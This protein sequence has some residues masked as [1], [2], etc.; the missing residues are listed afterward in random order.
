MKRLKESVLI[1][2]K[3]TVLTF[4]VEYTPFNIIKF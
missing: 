2:S 1:L 4:P 3:K